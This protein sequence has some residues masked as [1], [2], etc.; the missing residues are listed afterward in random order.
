MLIE[1][2][3]PFLLIRNRESGVRRQGGGFRGMFGG[4]YKGPAPLGTE[5]ASPT[6][7]RQA[8]SCIPHIQDPDLGVKKGG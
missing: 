4:L 8:D 6:S 3:R 1:N 5:A 2:S 7:L